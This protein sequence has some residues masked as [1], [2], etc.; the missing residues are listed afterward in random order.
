MAT[1]KPTPTISAEQLCALTGLTDK[2]HRQLAKDGFFPPPI[3][4]EYQFRETINGMFRYYREM[5]KRARGSLAEQQLAKAKADRELAELEVARQRR[6]VVPTADVERT[7][8]RFIMAVRARLLQ[9]PAKC[10]VAFP[11]WTDARACEQ[12]IDAEARDICTEL[13]ESPDYDGT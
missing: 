13:A 3:K 9:L 10:V 12:W 2:R 11:T 6:E 7:W 1:Q 5:T 8:T 4:G